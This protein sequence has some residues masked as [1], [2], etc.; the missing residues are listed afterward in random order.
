MPAKKAKTPSK[1]TD[2]IAE[3]KEQLAQM[4]ERLVSYEQ[5]QVPEEYPEVEVKT[6]YSWKSPQRMF[7]QR[8]RRWFIY[9]ILIVLLISLVLLFFRQFITIAP[10]LAIAF[11]AYVFS[12]VPPEDTEH[13]ITTQG[14]T[15]SNHSYLWEE[16]A[17]FWF[18]ERNDQTILHIDTWLNFPRRLIVLI[19]DGNKEDIKGFL[20]R[21]IP[22]RE[23]PKTSWMDRTSDYLSAKFHKI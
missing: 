20:A 15:S 21:Y 5:T 2:S 13:H 23:I 18:T 1:K 7:V 8:K 16:L 4:Q 17:D 6:L 9:I 10:L 11:V 3:L 14:L 12:S 19:G 22:F